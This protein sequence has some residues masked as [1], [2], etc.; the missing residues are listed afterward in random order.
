MGLLSR[1]V[2]ELKSEE[3]VLGVSSGYVSDEK[4]EKSPL[5][6]LESTKL[7]IVSSSANKKWIGYVAIDQSIADATVGQS[8]NGKLFPAR[9][10][11][12]YR[13]VSSTEKK[14]FEGQ[15]I[16]KD[17]EKLV[18]TGIEYICQVDLVDVKIPKVAG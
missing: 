6:G 18:V 2:A 16:Q 17:I 12:T 7:Q 1:H 4:N 9:C 5:F 14:T 8:M 10:L 3:F 11:V 13:R 15:T